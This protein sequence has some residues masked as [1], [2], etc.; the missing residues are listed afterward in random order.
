MFMRPLEGHSNGKT[1]SS[2][3][4]FRMLLVKASRSHPRACHRQSL[5]QL[6]MTLVEKGEG[7]HPLREG[8]KVPKYG[9]LRVSVRNHDYGLGK[10]LVFGYLDP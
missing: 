2:S 3:K 8:S 4:L 1:L 7:K 6:N 5:P 10:Y 9:V